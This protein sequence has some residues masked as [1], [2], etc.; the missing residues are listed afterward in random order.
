MRCLLSTSPAIA[1]EHPSGDKNADKRVCDVIYDP[2]DVVDV[3]AAVGEAMTIMFRASE[4]ID[5]VSASDTAHL[6]QAETKGSSVLWLKA[7]EP[8]QPQPISVV[9]LQEDGSLRNYMLQWSATAP[10]PSAPA[11]VAMTGDAQDVADVV[12]PQVKPRCALLL[13]PV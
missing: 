4:R 7:T 3:R 5:Y 13:D 2:S 12:A 1:L 9:T 11:R 8:M 6:K 10:V